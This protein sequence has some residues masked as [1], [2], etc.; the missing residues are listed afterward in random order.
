[1]GMTLEISRSQTAGRL[2]VNGDSYPLEEFT[3]IFTRLMDYRF[4]PELK[5]QPES[6]LQRQLCRNLLDTLNRW[7]EV[8]PA[9]VVNRAAPMSSNFS[10]PFQAQLIRRFGFEVPETLITNDPELVKAF[11]ARHQRI[12]YKSISG[13]RSIVQT[14]NDGDMDRLESIRWCPTQFQAFVD[15]TNVRVHTVGQKVF[16]TAISTD[17]TDYRYAHRQGGD[18]AKLRAVELSDDLAE[19][20]VKLSEG[21][22]LAFAGID[23]KV[24]QEN[25]VYCFEVNPSPAFSYYEANTGQPIAQAVAAYLAGE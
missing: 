13:V 5:D 21:L 9:R 7:A 2:Q 14:F 6:S 4:L 19:M 22:G 12:I 25:R 11:R 16:A 1:M 24:T 23:L 20:C 3:A 15:G 17:A 10:K 8:A 18:H